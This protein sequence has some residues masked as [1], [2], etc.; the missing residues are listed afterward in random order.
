V[1]VIR[2]RRAWTVGRKCLVER[3]PR[4]QAALS[5]AICQR[6]S[7]E[8][9]SHYDDRTARD[10][11][12]SCAHHVGVAPLSGLR[13]APPEL[14]QATTLGSCRGALVARLDSITRRRTISRRATLERGPTP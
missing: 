9:H 14:T 8:E 6:S 10:A 4:R 11:R 7:E 3:T 5:Q 2:C 12:V 13:T 1:T